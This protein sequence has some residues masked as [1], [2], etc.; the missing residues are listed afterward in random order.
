M[1]DNNETENNK[2]NK[3]LRL[4][5]TGK[6]IALINT[7]I[8]GAISYYAIAYLKGMISS[9]D[10][11]NQSLGLIFLFLFIGILGWLRDMITD[12]LDMQS[13]AN[14]ER[15]EHLKTKKELDIKK[16]QLDDCRR[17]IHAIRSNITNTIMQEPDDA[18]KMK[19]IVG[20]MV[21]IN[22]DTSVNNVT[23]VGDSVIQRDYLSLFSTNTR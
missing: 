20:M 8:Y 21:K 10:R 5:H 11:T 6:L 7:A 15:D 12:T 16:S 17:M 2:W 18:E 4:K 3:F 13:P 19:K 14:K 22:S 1:P 9:E 23:E